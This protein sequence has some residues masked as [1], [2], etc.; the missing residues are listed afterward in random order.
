MA[1]ETVRAIRSCT[2]VADGLSGMN[3]GLNIIL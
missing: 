3:T 2:T 1:A